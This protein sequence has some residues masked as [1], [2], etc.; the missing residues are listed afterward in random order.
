MPVGINK[1]PRG[2]SRKIAA[3]RA[4]VGRANAV[5]SRRGGMSQGGYGPSFN[6]GYNLG[7]RGELK[8]VDTSNQNIAMTT[9]WQLALVNGVAQ[10]TDYTNRVGRKTTMKSV[11]FNGNVFNLST[12][13]LNAFNGAYCRLVIIYDTQPNSGALP[14]GTDIF[15]T[16]DPNSPL[17][18]NNRDRFQVLMDVRKQVSAFLMNA[19]PA[20][21]TGNPSNAYFKKYMKCN[22][23]T[24]FS[25]TANTISSISTGAVYLCFI[26]DFAAAAFDYYIRIRFTDL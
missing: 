4:A 1:R 25:G 3:A 22:K 8:F 21:A 23:D 18:L 16:N 19:T 26:A 24:I 20:L 11:I 10:G 6:R 5:L 12:A 2:T 14:A 9:S 13:S 15:A 7:G 17:N